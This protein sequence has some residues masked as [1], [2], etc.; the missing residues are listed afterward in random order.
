MASIVE[1][2]EIPLGDLIIGLGQVRTREVARDINEL[3]DSIAQVGLL[4]P[5]VVCP[6]QIEGKYEI[7][8]GQR[9]FLAHSELNKE[10]IWAAVLD[11]DLPPK[12]WSS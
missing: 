2:K 6:T 1:F 7:I 10:T 5:I 12:N 4:E 3:A 9:R 8:T 11:G